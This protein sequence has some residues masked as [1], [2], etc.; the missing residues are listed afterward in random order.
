MYPK[1]NLETDLDT[2]PIAELKRLSLL[3]IKFHMKSRVKAQRYYEKNGENV[4]REQS[5]TIL[6]KNPYEKMN[7]LLNMLAT[8][9]ISISPI[10]KTSKCEFQPKFRALKCTNSFLPKKCHLIIK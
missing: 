6:Y 5:E 7:I 2:L 4:V 9:I 1:Y 10:L 3:A 8:M